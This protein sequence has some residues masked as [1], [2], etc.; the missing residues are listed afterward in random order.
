[1]SGRRMLGS[2]LRVVL[3]RVALRAMLMDLGRGCR[4]GGS[5]FSSGP[6]CMLRV[7]ARVRFGEV[8]RRGKKLRLLI[9]DKDKDKDKVAI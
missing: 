7:L 5:G 6:F 1:M 8:L 3:T 4:G 2:G 9:S